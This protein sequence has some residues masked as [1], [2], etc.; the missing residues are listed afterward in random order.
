MTQSIESALVEIKSSLSQTMS[1]TPCAILPTKQLAFID[2]QNG[3]LLFYNCDGNF[4][5]K[6]EMHGLFDLTPIDSKH[7][8]VA[9]DGNIK[10]VDINTKEIERV[11][12]ECS[13]IK[14]GMCYGN[15]KTVRC[16][17]KTHKYD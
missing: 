4:S 17:S 7:I 3:R 16:G 11:I 14:W 1:L 2:N 5:G 12:N 15:G 9:A 13:D 8:A 10:I 6:I